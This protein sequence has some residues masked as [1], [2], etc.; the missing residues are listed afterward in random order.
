MTVSSGPPSAPPVDLLQTAS[1]LRRLELEVSR[2][3]DGIITGDYLAW[4]AGPGT[5]RTGARRYEPADDARRIDWNLSAR[6]LEPQ[7]RTTQADRELETTIIVDRSASLDFGTSRREKR[8]VVLA[9]VAAF[10]ILTARGGNRLHVLVAGGDQLIRIPPRHDRRGVMAALATVDGTPRRETPPAEGADLA[11]AIDQVDRITKRRGLIV[12]VSDFLDRTN[13]T[14][15]LRRLAM[16]HQ[17][18]TVAVSDPRELTL[19]AVGM[20]TLVDS[21][22]GRRVHVPSNSAA[23]RRRYAEAAQARQENIKR[24]LVATGAKHLALSTDRDWVLDIANFVTRRREVRG[25]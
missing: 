17:V 23:L 18:L 5:E 6:S 21:E 1:V 25:L 7:V 4:S 10:G 3:L 12:V 2:R 22:S 19:P 8:E 20:L 11:A 15:P 13:W 16:R 9:V 14:A 24:D